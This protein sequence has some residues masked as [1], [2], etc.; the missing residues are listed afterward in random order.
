LTT[1]HR[2]S[3]DFTNDLETLRAALFRIQSMAMYRS[4]CTSCGD[5]SF[6]LGNRVANGDE[7]ALRIA[8]GLVITEGDSLLKSIGGALPSR[9]GTEALA[10]IMAD[11]AVWK[12]EEETALSLGTIASVARRMF[13][14]AGRRNIILLSHGF[15]VPKEQQGQLMQMVDSVL[16]S[17]VTIQTVNS[18]G[19]LTGF[20]TGGSPLDDDTVEP[21]RPSGSTA[22]RESEYQARLAG[23][24]TLRTIADSTG[25]TAIENSTDFL[26]AVRRLATPLEYRYILGFTPRDLA[27]DGSFHKLTVKLTNS[28]Y[29][30]YTPQARRGYY[31]PKQDEGLPQAAEKEIEAA[32]FSR[33]DIRDVPVEMRTDL[34]DEELTVSADVDLKLLHFRVADGRNCEEVTA[35]AAVFDHDGNFISGERQTLTLKL[36]DETLAGLSQKP[37]ETLRSSFTLSPGT[38]LV[39]LV[40]HSAEDQ[41]MTEVSKLVDIP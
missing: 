30:S 34:K 2:V 20:Q 10:R 41:A 35:V 8:K 18:A 33:D 28:A 36:R 16:R 23:A 11:R 6:S 24:E 38:Y 4:V 5:L 3:T 9:E 37:P 19:L 39:R 13:R 32:I 12:G 25:G 14:L 29:K 15:V 1:S 27:A 40:V 31:A 17:G 7:L 26:G 22:I 21:S